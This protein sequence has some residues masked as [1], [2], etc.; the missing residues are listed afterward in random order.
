[1]E[2]EPETTPR[3]RADIR[4]SQG[5]Q[6]EFER[7]A[8]GFVTPEGDTLFTQVRPDQD[9]SGSGERWL[10][11]SFQISSELADQLE[12]GVAYELI[13]VDGSYIDGVGR[14]RVGSVFF[15]TEDR[16]GRIE[17]VYEYVPPE[18]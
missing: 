9:D 13:A 11:D 6:E 5:D 2:F 14:D 10:T 12:V 15:S 8:L 18:N 4:L 16:D 3:V 17:I 1:L 7:Y